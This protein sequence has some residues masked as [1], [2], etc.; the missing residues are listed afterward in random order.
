MMSHD[1][2]SN[3]TSHFHHLDIR[4][5]MVPL[6]MPFIS[7]DADSNVVVSHDTNT[8]ANGIM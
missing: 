6:I 4:N 8:N 2:K 5:V 7:H 1:Q 3:V